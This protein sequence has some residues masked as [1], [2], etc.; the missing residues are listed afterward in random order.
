MK[1]QYN[2]SKNT[3]IVLAVLL[4]FWTWCYTYK[5]DMAKF[6]IGLAVSFVGIMAFGIPNIIIWIWSIIDVCL[7]DKQFFE[8]YYK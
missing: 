3:S 6:W 1:Y 8:Q 2:K 7:K 4:G 5:Y